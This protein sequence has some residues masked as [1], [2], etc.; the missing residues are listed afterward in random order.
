M[1]TSIFYVIVSL[2]LNI[3]L[4]LI[5]L[6]NNIEFNP[7]QFPARVYKIETLPPN[8]KSALYYMVDQNG[9]NFKVKMDSGKYSIND[10][11]VLHDVNYE[12]YL[13]KKFYSPYTTN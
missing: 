11:I 10:T 9:T 5:L 4:G 12:K 8:Y 3:L 13:E 7:M 1:K 2:L 6:I